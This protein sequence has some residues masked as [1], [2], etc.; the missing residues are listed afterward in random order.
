[1]AKK[2]ENQKKEKS[3]KIPSPTPKKEEINGDIDTFND[4][5]VVKYEVLPPKK[6]NFYE[7]QFIIHSIQ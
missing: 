5:C 1:M 6:N 3:K 2:K 7:R 4:S